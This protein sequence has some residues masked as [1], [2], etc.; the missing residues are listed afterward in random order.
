MELDR[1]LARGR[2][3]G[4]IRADASA[5]DVIVFGALLAQALPHTPDWD[6]VARRQAAIY[7]AGLQ[8]DGAPLGP[9]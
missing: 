6:A 5:A 7:V 1:V 3:E 9:R 4:G 2:E 8:A